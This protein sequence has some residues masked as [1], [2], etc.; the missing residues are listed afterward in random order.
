MANKAMTSTERGQK[1]RKKLKHQNLKDLRVEMPCI[2]HQ[3]F[4]TVAKA[5]GYRSV[6][7]YVRGEHRKMA[8]SL[9]LT[10]AF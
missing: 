10:L 3:S 8:L 2:E 6:S 1:R 9:G 4:A 7:E 5:A